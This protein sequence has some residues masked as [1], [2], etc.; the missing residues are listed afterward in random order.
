MYIFPLSPIP[1]VNKRQE[2]KAR[3]WEDHFNIYGRGVSMY[4]TNEVANLVLSGVPDHLRMNIWMSFSG[5]SYNI[6]TTNL[7]P[8]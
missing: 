6:C 4:R 2:T 5:S 8:L 3:E 1:E 7:E